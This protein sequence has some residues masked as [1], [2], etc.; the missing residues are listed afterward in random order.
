MEHNFW[1][2]TQ[3]M[4]T[5]V[6]GHLLRDQGAFRSCTQ[7]A[8]IWIVF[9]LTMGARVLRDRALNHG[10]CTPKLRPQFGGLLHMIVVVVGTVGSIS[11]LEGLWK[12]LSDPSCHWRRGPG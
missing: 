3:I 4:L 12:C 8:A 2:I 7:K 5:A 10:A 11:S 9:N 1:I 6:G